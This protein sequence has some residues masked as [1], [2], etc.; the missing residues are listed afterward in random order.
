MGKIAIVLVLAMAASR[1]VAA[2]ARA[3]VPPDSPIYGDIDRLSAAGLIDTIVIGTRP[4]TEREIVRLLSE[5]KRNL[6]RRA[7]ETEWASRAIAAGLR[8]YD[9]RPAQPGVQSVSVE[10]TV[11]DSPYRP[12]PGDG[13]GSIDAT[14]NPL[15]SYRVGRP[16]EKGTTTTVES[17][18]D[19]SIGRFFAA[20]LQPGAAMGT[21]RTRTSGAAFRLQSGNVLGAFGNLVIDAGRGYVAF[22]QSYPSGLLLSGNAP[23]LDMIRISTERPAALPWLFRLLGPMYGTLFV[24]DLGTSHQVHPHAK[25]V[26][27]HLSMLPHPNVEIGAEVIDE[28]GGDGS[29]PGTFTDRVIDLFPVFD[30]PLL[31]MLYRGYGNLRFSNKL[32]GV[33]SRIRVPSV[34][35]M[36]LYTEIALDDADIRRLRSTLLEDGGIIGGVAW[37]C[38]IECG[39][40]VARFEYHQ[41]G[42]RY[43]THT[44]FS[45]GVQQQGDLLGDPL[46]PRGLGGYATLD[47]EA[48]RFGRLKASVAHE[49]RSGNLYR[50]AAT[51]STLS[52]FHFE[53]ILHRPG[54]HRTRV[55]TEW[56]TGSVDSRW[57]GAIGFGVE[58]VTNADFVADR[59]RLNSMARV[60]TEWRP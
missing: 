37:S 2:Q 43:Y 17:L 13:N 1:G 49:V 9:N 55:G 52:D 31:E 57:S 22:S 16:L 39:R 51:D 32:V 29:P 6:N 36:E 14:I 4:Y 5:A 58:L 41:T 24:A 28:T 56:R 27:Y 46:G 12:I 48:G 50:S 19:A 44:D 11:L 18:M 35:G 42:I 3:F 25:L 47:A 53:Q 20:S 33:D 59:R 10:L 54:E 60:S 21:P 40:V 23:P 38:L 26:G 30:L 45:S 8:R 7:G 34:A 15:A